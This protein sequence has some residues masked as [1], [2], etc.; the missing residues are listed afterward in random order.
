[1]VDLLAQAPEHWLDRIINAV[2]A[3]GEPGSFLWFG[4]NLRA[5]LALVLVSLICGAVGSLVVGGRMA[6]F[7]DALAHCAF[8][9]VSIGFL[10]FETLLRGLRPADEFWDWVTPIMIAFGVLVGYGIAAVRQR[11]GLAS[12]TVIGVFFAAAIGLAAMLRKI[13]HSRQLFNLEDFLFGDPLLVRSQDIVQLAVLLV[14]TALVLVLIYNH[15]L[16]TG[17]NTSL[18]LSRRVPSRLANYVFVMLLA[19]IVNLCLRCVGVLLINALLVVPAATAANISRNMRQLFWW[20]VALCLTVSLLGQW[21]SWEVEAGT[22]NRLRLGI[23]GTIILFSVLLF[24]FLPP[25]VRLVRRLSRPRKG[26]AGGA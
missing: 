20:T 6:F 21:V 22:G 24:V 2:A 9:G 5:L 19:V 4:Y 26:L 3:L 11:T 13:I 1:M 23:P 12:D 10:F 7:S 17:F 25:L 18:A 15:L 8:A 16:L 14:F